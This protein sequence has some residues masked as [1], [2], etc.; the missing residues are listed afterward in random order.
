M[1]R[2]IKY[3]VDLKLKVVQQIL[4]GKE[5]ADSISFKYTISDSIVKRWVD[6]YRLHGIDGLMPSNRHYS[7]EFKLEVV[8]AVKS[9]SLSLNKAC[10]QFRIS[11]VSTLK[12]WLILFDS[13]GAES[14]RV[15]RRGRGKP[16][17]RTPAMPRKPKRPLTR[18][19]QLLEELADLRAENA[20]LKKLQALIQ[21]ESAKEEKRKSSKN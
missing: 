15:E 3:D 16:K 20:Y 10:C 18:E 13:C 21:S 6:F 7:P 4:K 8:Q 14:L 12:K 19:E 1:S 2:K 11:S 5:S 17:I 9:K